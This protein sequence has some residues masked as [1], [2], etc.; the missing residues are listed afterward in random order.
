MGRGIVPC[1]C[2]EKGERMKT[3]LV[4]LAIAL[5]SSFGLANI[6]SE[7]EYLLNHHLGD[8]GQRTQ[9]GTL[10]NKTSNVLIAK[11][12]YAVQGGS[13]AADISLLTDLTDSNSLAILPAKS[14]IRNAWLQILTQPASPGVDTLA[15]RVNG[16]G[17]IY[18]ATAGN[19]LAG[20]FYQGTPAGT[21]TTFIKL[22]AA[23]TVKL[24]L[25]LATNSQLTAG[26][27]NVIIDY[28]I[29]D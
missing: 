19:F 9:V 12:S 13:T 27:F 8:V 4:F 21:T 20:N 6:T 26:K 7:Q 17:D 3:I 1:S 28:L 22:S 29:G 25:G 2:P 18:P 5:F 24:R 10:I 11:Y 15:I 14:I 23:S 16:A